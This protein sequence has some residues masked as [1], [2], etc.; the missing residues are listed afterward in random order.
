M[1]SLEVVR[2]RPLFVVVVVRT[3]F[4]ARLMAA[5]AAVTRF[6]SREVLTVLGVSRH[7]I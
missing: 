6:L 7:L 3:R 4:A 5:S 1:A 2:F